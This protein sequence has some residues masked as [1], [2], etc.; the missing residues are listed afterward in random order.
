M[1]VNKTAGSDKFYMK[2]M[3]EAINETDDSLTDVFHMSLAKGKGSHG[4]KFA[5]VTPTFKKFTSFPCLY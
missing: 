4:W 5:N 3:K 2:T 1:K